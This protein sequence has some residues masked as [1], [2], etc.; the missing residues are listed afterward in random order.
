MEEHKDYFSVCYNIMKLRYAE[1]DHMIEGLGFLYPTDKVNVF[2][3][4]ES[5]LKLL[6][7]VRDVE[8]KVMMD[9][10][11]SIIMM[12]D[13]LNLAAH[14]K[15]FFV[16]NRLRTR[17]FL[18]MTDWDSTEFPEFLYNDEYRSYYLTKYNKNPKFDAL[19]EEFKNIVFP[20]V[21][22]IF[23]FIPDV[24]FISTKN[25][26]GS[27]VPFIIGEMD[28]S[29]KNFII[30][31]DIV[32]T[33]YSLH[34]NYVNFCLKRSAS[35][36]TT[37]NVKGY[38]E[39][40]FKV[41]LTETNTT[42][43]LNLYSNRPLYLSLLASVGEPHRNIERVGDLTPI[44]NTK[45]IVSML[46]THKI[47]TNISS[48]TLLGESYPDEYREEMKESLSLLDLEKSYASLSKEQI[49]S[50]TSQLID[51]FDHN[52]LLKLN[53]TLFHKHSLMLEELT[54]NAG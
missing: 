54:C 20:Q 37:C 30:G 44:R 38:L 45:C 43:F 6:C 13:M 18:Y 49:Y 36:S 32:D 14:Y 27:L 41:K 42:T 9:K 53:Q 26:E 51:R 17:V 4:F 29:Y 35:G 23:D 15:R 46:Q 39:K 50:V 1:F 28:P 3:N 10:E 21:K 16:G 11:F 52:A 2:I 34:P 31:N 22:T 5:V 8:N 47:Q 25:I 40:L 24:Y 12:A 19:K 48:V 33:Q 7:T